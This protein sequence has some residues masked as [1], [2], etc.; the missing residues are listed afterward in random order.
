M[1]QNR[2]VFPGLGQ[3]NDDLSM[4]YQQINDN[5]ARPSGKVKGGGTVYPGMENYAN[6]QAQEHSNRQAPNSKPVV[7]FLYSISK[8][9]AGEFWPVHVGQ[10]VIGSDP[11]NDIVLREA[12]VSNKH[13]ILHI[14]KMKK[15]EKVEA[16]ISDCQ[17]T[18]GTMLNG[19]SVSVARPPECVNGD[20]IT[21]GEN[22]ELVFILID[23]KTFGL[24]KAENFIPLDDVDEEDEEDFYDAQPE[25]GKRSTSTRLDFPPRFAGPESLYDSSS[26]PTEGTVGMDPT[27]GTP[28]RKGGT[29]GMDN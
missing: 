29:V 11:S 13:A 23:I 19:E 25:G 28:F 18:N 5:Y 14:N 27:A 2:T 9:I 3:E 20:V 4:R 21:I 12:T 1:S 26:R 6:P 24:S 17:S 16:T 7:G 10:N 15:P 22:Y 8:T